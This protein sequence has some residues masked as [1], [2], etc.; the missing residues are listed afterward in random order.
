L[1]PGGL[2]FRRTNSPAVTETPGTA[3]PSNVADGEGLEQALRDERAR[4]DALIQDLL[5][6]LAAIA[7]STAAIP[8]DEHDAEG[9]TVGYERARVQALLAHAQ[10]TSAELDSAAQRVTNDTY[11]RC[12]LC[13]SEIPA[14]RL[15]ALPATRSCVR[16]AVAVEHGTIM[17]SE[18][19][20]GDS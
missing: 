17:R 8:D 5:L 20:F 9:S 19:G 2:V 6:E 10:R 12:S 15:A 18:N 1:S 13:G 11:A 14:E 16:C 3:V 4:A 7:E